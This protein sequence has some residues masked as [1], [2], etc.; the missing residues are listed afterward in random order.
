MDLVII[1]VVVVDESVK[2][3]VERGMD[4]CG[5]EIPTKILGGSG[6]I[7]EIRIVVVICE[8]GGVFI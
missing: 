8:D 5:S 2:K 6:G 1:V 4:I 7:E 3:G